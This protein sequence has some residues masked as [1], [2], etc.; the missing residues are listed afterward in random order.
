MVYRAKKMRIVLMSQYLWTWLYI[1]N[2]LVEGHC[3]VLAWIRVSGGLSDHC[4]HWL[5]RITLMSVPVPCL[6]SLSYAAIVLFSRGFSLF[7][8]RHRFPPFSPASF[9]CTLPP[10]IIVLFL[11]S[12]PLHWNH[13]LTPDTP[14]SANLLLL[15][16]LCQE[17][18]LHG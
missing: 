12:S 8:H 9:N 18:D 7:A 11:L 13:Y 14:A 10:L 3:L 1:A 5:L 15:P 17:P 4:C 16:T 6:M 2:P